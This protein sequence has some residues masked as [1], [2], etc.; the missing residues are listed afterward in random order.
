MTLSIDEV[1]QRLPN[2]VDELP[3]EGVTI[4]WH[5]RPV[6]RFV[7]MEA[8]QKAEY[9]TRALINGEVT[10]PARYVRPRATRLPSLFPDAAVYVAGFVS[11]SPIS[12]RAELKLRGA[13]SSHYNS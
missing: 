8:V 9:V 1:R 13:E 5:G 11:N 12:S 7:P 2:L 4:T 10:V 3:A 6:A